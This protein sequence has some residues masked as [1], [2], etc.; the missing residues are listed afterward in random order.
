[1]TGRKKLF[2]TDLDGTLLDDRKQISE[3]NRE[4]IGQTLSAGHQI[5]I[6]S[7][8]AVVGVLRQA[9]A[10]GLTR[11][12]CYAIAYNGAAVVRCDT[13]E[14]LYEKRLPGELIRYLFSEAEKA[15]IHCQTYKGDLTLALHQT[16]ELAYYH[17]NNRSR[18][19]VVS[20]ISG[21]TEAG[22]PKV[23]LADLSHSGRLQQFREQHRDILEE[24]TESM[25]S[26]P[27]YLEYL[28]K[29]TNKGEAALWLCRYLG[30]DPADTVA[31]GD[32]END[33]PMLRVAGIGACMCNGTDQAKQAADY[34]TEADNNHSGVAEII[35]RFILE[36]H[37]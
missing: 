36:K 7:G 19:L 5:V 32:E 23:L 22:A 17:N 8:R 29:H 3:G 10:L 35:K 27:E 37:S 4:A 26:C 13:K 20:D 24:K 34:V 21:E 12:G 30:I 6:S 2:F 28:P 16:P 15:G 33:I 14:I 31:A 25:F 11:Q 1:M 18:S 9:K